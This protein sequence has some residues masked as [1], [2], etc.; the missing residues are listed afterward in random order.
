MTDYLT[1]IP[2]CHQQSPKIESATMLP[3]N[4]SHSKAK[5]AYFLLAA[6]VACTLA[7]CGDA[8]RNRLVGQWGIAAPEAVM[9]RID[10]NESDSEVP[11]ET[12][13]SDRMVLTFKRNGVVHTRTTMGD[14]DQ[15]K[16]G[17]WKLV[18]FDEASNLMA[19][20]CEINTQKSDHEI[21][22]VDEKTIKLVPPNMAG[23]KM[24]LKFSKLNE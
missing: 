24:K 7:G 17:T 16:T 21:T 9:N 14:I 13:I 4:P 11:A 18:S 15:E 19:I 12:E 8:N 23:L 22:F 6:V 5:S 2:C 1:R 10:K 20:S 3:T